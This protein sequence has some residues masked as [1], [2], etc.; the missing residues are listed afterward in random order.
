MAGGGAA[1][2]AAAAADLEEAAGLQPDRFPAAVRRL[3]EACWVA[4]PLER[5][6][7]AEVGRKLRALCKRLEQGIP[8]H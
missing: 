3:L 7:A 1:A 6:D 4:N 8:L 2:S 5:L